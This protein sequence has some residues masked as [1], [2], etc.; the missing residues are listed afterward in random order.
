M[1]EEHFAEFIARVRADPDLQDE[2]KSAVT[3]DDVVAVASRFGYTISTQDLLPPEAQ[4]S[5]TELQAAV[6]GWDKGPHWS[7]IWCPT[8]LVTCPQ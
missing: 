5:D 3:N 6:G 8:A 1:S 7:V 4:L 2:L